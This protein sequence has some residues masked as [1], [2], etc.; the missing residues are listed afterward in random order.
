MVS[1][2]T[3]PVR[4]QQRPDNLRTELPEHGLD[5]LALSLEQLEEN[6]LDAL[7]VLEV[8]AVDL[9]DESDEL[10]ALLH[11]LVDHFG[12]CVLRKISR[13]HLPCWA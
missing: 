9:L 5:A 4:V 12:D 10:G 3:L 1:D 7:D 13:Q 11:A 2:V 8:E 6:L